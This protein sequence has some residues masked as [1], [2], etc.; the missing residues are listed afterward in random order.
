MNDH[1]LFLEII[2]VQSMLVQRHK[3]VWSD[4]MKYSYLIQMDLISS[5]PSVDFLEKNM[6]NRVWYCEERE[7]LRVAFKS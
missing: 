1:W 6:Q 5:V 2:N 4:G 3:L 7:F